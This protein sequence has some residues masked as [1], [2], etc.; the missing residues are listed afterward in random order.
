MQSNHLL[1]IATIAFVSCRESASQV[2]YQEAPPVAPAARR[3]HGLDHDPSRA[4]TVL[5]GGADERSSQVFGDTWEYDGAEW[6]LRSTTGAPPRQRFAACMD[7]ARGR[8][9][10]FGGIAADGRGL[11]DTWQWDGTSWIP[12][13]TLHAPPPRADARMVFDE[14]RGRVVLFGGRPVDPG[15]PY[16]DTWEFDGADW[17]QR[18]P[19]GAPGPRFG[20]A[21]TFDARRGVSVVFGGFVNGAGGVGSDTWAYDGSAWVPVATAT[22]PAGCVFPA[23][24]THR[25][26]GVLVLTGGSGSASQALATYVWDGL[27]W[28]AGPAAPP[29][30]ASRQG[31]A[32]AYD[33]AREALVLFG[34]ASI[35]RGGAVPRADT[36]ELSTPASF[37]PFGHGCATSAGV[38]EL[39]AQSRP[40]L[41]RTF[42]LAVGT[43]PPA[44][45]PLLLLGRSDLVWQG[46]PLPWDLARLGM[47]GCSLFTSI[48]VAGPMIPLGQTAHASLP[49]P[50]DRSL[51]GR[52]LFAQAVAL[53]HE[54]ATSNAGRVAFGN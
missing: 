49:I 29:E 14:G 35:A 25:A 54:A 27:D 16:G 20:H 22:R 12:T 52:Q 3:F 18:A 36:W 5:F 4:V 45:W 41:G 6:S 21:M 28:Q 38:L 19:A 15:Q 43:L 7:R 51:L 17:M 11:G 33:E 42:S 44:A 9:V 31:H 40:V 30:L 32:T 13:L 26:H 2:W 46:M 1:A 50:L 23:L 37:T 48:D 8:F 39:K 47:P 34:G 24:S 53:G 10:V